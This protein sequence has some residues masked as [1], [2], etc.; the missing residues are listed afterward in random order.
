MRRS[1]LRPKFLCKTLVE[2]SEF[3]GSFSPIKLC[4]RTEEIGL[5]WRCRE[6]LRW[7]LIRWQSGWALLISLPK[8]VR[9]IRC[10]RTLMGISINSEF[11]I[12]PM[13]DNDGNWSVVTQ[14]KGQW[15]AHLVL[16]VNFQLLGSPKTVFLWGHKWLLLPVRLKN[17]PQ[18]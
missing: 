13:R 10:S 1:E 15:Q 14:L 12:L 8:I 6:R 17:L 5:R 3:K 4:H 9:Q 18:R 11:Y 7:R 2:M 16:P